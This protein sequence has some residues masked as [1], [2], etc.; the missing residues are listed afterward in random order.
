M[1]RLARVLLLL[2]LG[3][4]T[5]LVAQQPAGPSL[6]IRGALVVD[7]TGAVARRVDVRV[8]GDR[9]RE[10]GRLTVGPRD[11]VLDATGLVLAPGFIDTHS[12]HDDGLEAEPGALAAV[13]QGITTIVV[14]QDGW[15]AFPL[16]DVFARYEQAPAAVNLASY[17]GHGR[18]RSLVLGEHYQ[19]PSTPAEIGHMSALLAQEMKAGAL[20][21]SSGLE[22]DP[23]IYASSKELLALA[24]VAARQGGR[25]ISHIRSED[26]A[27]WAAIDEALAIGRQAKL[28][29]QISHAKLAM[30][31][32]WGNADS[33]VG[34]LERARRAGV[35]VS[36]DIYP[37]TY[38]QSTL[39]VLF[40]ERNYR[41][42]AAAEFALTETTSADSAW[43][44]EYEPDTTLAGQ[45]I[46]AI[47]KLRG[48]D[49][50]GTLMDL[51]ARVAE[52]RPGGGAWNESIIAVS[53]FQPDLDTLIA[54]P[55]ANIGSDGSL[56][57]S[58]PRG[59][60]AFPRFFRLYVRERPL[61]T[62]E[63]AVRRTT[64]LAASNVGL[65]RRGRLA[66]GYYADL[67]LLDTTALA[68]RATPDNPRAL[69]TGIRAVWVNGTLVFVQGAA[70]GARPGRVLRRVSAA[71][72][73]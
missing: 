62:L 33:L 54:W 44:G 22:Y 67:V 1:R 34:I 19:R 35:R 24:R 50:P 11:S 16:G 5:P 18:L 55:F 39:T 42:R 32:L 47:A 17:V 21:L 37:Y 53:M 2:G 31:S 8:R 72:G 60:G 51:T 40:P 27:F 20:G 15:S 41:D 28:P 30:R 56:Q 26:R 65:A 58:H 64:S 73:P 45:S 25:Y 43:L 63:E 10:I 69:S 66:P 49:E 61:L 14:G 48:H 70:T 38:W 9:V 46:A 52:P 71:G 4:A 23:G 59:V 13:S 68:D 6:L 3:A 7:G 57:G 36:L 12:H 29:V